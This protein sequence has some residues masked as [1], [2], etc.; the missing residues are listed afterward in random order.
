MLALVCTAA[1]AAQ[2]SAADPP[3]LLRWAGDPEGGAPFVEADPRN[4]NR[5]VGFDVE[6]ADLIAR[7]LGREA[8]F[9]LIAFTSLDQSI[10]RGDAEIALSGIEDTPA[11][12]AALSP[13]IPYYEFREVLAVR[14]ADAARVRGL[15]D[16]RGRRVATLGGTIAYDILV[17]AARDIGLQPLSYDDDV[18]PYE[19]LVLGRVDAVLLDNVLAERRRRAL[20]GFTV[21][22]DAVAIGHYIGLLSAANAPL[23]DSIN[24]VLRTAMREGAL[25]RIFRRWG[26]WND[27]QRRLYERLVRGEVV[28]AILSGSSAGPDQRT[29]KDRKSTRLNSSHIQKSRMPSSA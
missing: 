2:A 22:P 29:A 20:D 17:R 15:T 18:H 13:T 27:D 3:R 25:E 5:M 12:R 19:D 6:I 1:L 11:R 14:D 23:R 9:V 24:E 4:P 7:A 16:L 21:L 28:D 26:V 10:N 8:K